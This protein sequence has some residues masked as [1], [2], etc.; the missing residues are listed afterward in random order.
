M[1]ERSRKL[2]DVEFED[3]IVALQEGH[4][5]FDSAEMLQRLGETIVSKLWETDEFSGESG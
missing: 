3:A 1:Y 5:P 2:S 4:V